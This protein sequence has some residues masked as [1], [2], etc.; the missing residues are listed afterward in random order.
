MLVIDFHTIERNSFSLFILR[1]PDKYRE[2][3]TIITYD[4]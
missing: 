2:R 1:N 4:I 3:M